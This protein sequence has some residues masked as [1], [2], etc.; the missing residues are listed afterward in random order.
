VHKL[1]E[2]RLD[3]TVDALVS[4]LNVL[5]A[6]ALHAI[7]RENVLMTR[8]N[9]ELARLRRGA[10][11][12]RAGE[13][14]RWESQIA[15]D[16]QRVIAAEA[17]RYTLEE[18]LN[19]VLHRPL[20]ERFGAEDVVAVVGPN[21]AVRTTDPY[22]LTSDERLVAYANNLQTWSLFRDF[23][24][25]E[26]LAASPE[27]GQVDVGITAQERALQSARHAFWAP[28]IAVG[29]SV[30]NRFA[31]SG[32]GSGAYTLPD[33]ASSSALFPSPDGVN[34]SV[35]LTFSIPIT[36]GGTRLA[37]RAK[38][39]ETLSQLHIERDA[40]A[41]RIEQRIRASLH[42]LGTSYMNV[43]L[44]AEAARAAR[45]HLEL[46]RDAYR[47]GAVSIT[48]VLDAQ[49]ATL[50]AEQGTVVTRHDFVRDYLTMRRSTGRVDFFMTQD[51]REAFMARMAAYFTAR[52]VQ[53]TPVR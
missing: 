17:L 10:G 18:A 35:G 27:L 22:L 52:G 23:M 8:S 30:E 47:R 19:R 20:E 50:G 32:A 51:E 4:Y 2:V 16:R 3:V 41:E 26:G 46:V 53:P 37:G 25:E 12:A 15:V 1:E 49:R 14:L 11:I 31:R 21:G 48:E 36:T 42:K 40:A 45:E 24:V 44:A 13:V 33:P 29:A 5:Q 9:L 34:W 43:G 28:T 39:M 6:R 7:E 38:A